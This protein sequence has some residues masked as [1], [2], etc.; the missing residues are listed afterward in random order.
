MHLKMNMEL[1]MLTFLC[2]NC[3]IFC[4]VKY[5]TLFK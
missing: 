3:F 1:L 4:D 2:K 5:F